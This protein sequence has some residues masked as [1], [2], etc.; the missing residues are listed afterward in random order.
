MTL[1]MVGAG[2]GRTGTMSLKLALTKLLDGPVYHMLEVFPRPEH[3]EMWRDALRGNIPDWDVLFDGFVGA[4][5]WPTCTFWRELADTYPD[6]PVLLSTRDAAS[7]WKSCDQT[8]L[9]VFRGEADGNDA[10]IG[11]ATEM[12]KRFTPNFL[13]ADEMQAAFVRHTDEVRATVPSSRLIEWKPGDGW[14]PLCA[15]LGLPV[16][17][18]PYP[19]KNTT[20]EFRTRA[21]WDG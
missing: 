4:V 13:D 21:G 1:R 2:V 16:P 10:W 20:Q 8:I 14:E 3:I 12:L 5:D 15:G 11:M 6:A 18:E 19:H 17:D 7:W 9:N